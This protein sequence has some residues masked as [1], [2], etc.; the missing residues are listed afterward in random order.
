MTFTPNDEEF[1]RCAIEEAKTA[2]TKGDLPFG[3]I[4]VHDG[5]VVGKGH[6]ENNTIGDVTDHAELL[7]I[8]QACKTLGKNKLSDCVIYC[9]NEPC[10]M[11]A[12]GIFQ[13]DIAKVT[14]GVSR[15]ELPKL[16]RPRKLKIENL[17]DDSSYK[18]E[19]SRGLLKED[20]LPMFEGV[21]KK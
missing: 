14:I 17:A 1:M 20:I 6:A 21:Q 15:E 7:A 10:L 12:A 19:I 2:K 9:T 4:I 18:I 5:K 3:A 16:L 8:R 13:A 11:C